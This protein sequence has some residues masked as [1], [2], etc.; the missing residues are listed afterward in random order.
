M[1][2]A[3]DI[4]GPMSARSLARPAACASKT[5]MMLITMTPYIGTGRTLA[6]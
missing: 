3:F 2:L 4:A 1:T 5:T 6:L